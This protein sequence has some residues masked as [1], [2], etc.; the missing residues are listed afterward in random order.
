MQNPIRLRNQYVYLAIEPQIIEHFTF[1]L[2]FLAADL[3][4]ID[5]LQN[6]SDCAYE[7]KIPCTQ[8]LKDWIFSTFDS[9]TRADQR[10]AFAYRVGGIYLSFFTKDVKGGRIFLDRASSNFPRDSLILMLAAYHALNNEKN[11][12]RAADLYEKAALNGAPNWTHAL[13]VK[14]YKKSGHEDDARS[15]YET[16]KD[17]KLPENVLKSMR[18]QL[19][20]NEY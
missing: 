6:I 19:K 1:S 10:Y 15:L 13:A 17:A 16:L 8:E 12:S 18:D 11:E 7:S 4:W 14:L 2:K 3:L 9:I 20:I 5:A